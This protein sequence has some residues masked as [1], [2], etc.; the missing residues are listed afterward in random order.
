M[1]LPLVVG[2]DGSRSSLLAVDWAVDAAVAHGAPV[3]L[4]HAF[5]WQRYEG[6]ELGR[7][8]G[9]LSEKTVAEALVETAVDHAR[10]R[11]GELEISALAV[12]EDPVRT[13]LS[14]GRNASMLV[15]GSRGRGQ[16]AGL[17]L[18]SVSL[19]VAARA[20]CPVVVVRDSD[21]G[22]GERSRVAVGVGAADSG[23]QAVRFAF[24]E[25]EARHW[26]LLAVRA[27]RCPAHEPADHP[28]LTGDP[29]RHHRGQAAEIL[30]E[31]LAEAARDHPRVE[32]RRQVTEGQAGQVLLRASREAALLVVGARRGHGRSGLQ[33]GR[34]A[35]AALHHA[36]CPVA[37]VPLRE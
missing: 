29:A 9:R 25:A 21:D 27:W 26:A 37:V 20:D 28:L 14:E 24:R 3:R 5:L 12:P 22:S 31:A 2:V 7:D 1:E 13:L 36:S 34:V 15:L 8:L 10:R 35:H 17:L 32:V 19:A 6:A 18:G 11:R 4:V 30:D 23:S 16:L 33:L